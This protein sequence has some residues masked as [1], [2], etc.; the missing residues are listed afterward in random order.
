MTQVAALQM[1]VNSKVIGQSGVPKSDSDSDLGIFSE[2]SSESDEAVVLARSQTHIRVVNFNDEGFYDIRITA[3]RLGIIGAGAQKYH[4]IRNWAEEQ[5]KRGKNV[6]WGPFPRKR[7]FGSHSEKTM[8]ERQEQLHRWFGGLP[9]EMK[10]QYVQ[11]FSYVGINVEDMRNGETFQLHVSGD[12]PPRFIP[13]LIR[14]YLE[15][16]DDAIVNVTLG[17]QKLTGTLNEMDITDG[18]ILRAS[19][20]I[21]PVT[22][23][24]GDVYEGERN[25]ARG[26]HGLGICRYANGDVYQGEW[27]DNKENGHGT[28]TWARGTR[29]EGEW[30]NGQRH[31]EGIQTSHTGERYEGQWRDDWPDG[32]VK[33]T[34]P[35]G[36]IYEQQWKDGKKV[37]KS[38]LIA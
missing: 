13:Y 35:N 6:N 24:N 28:L 32:R 31:G 25:I 12:S 14:V 10:T 26:R 34:K 5:K 38:K 30:K 19:I 11:D 1:A 15:L 3:P 2:T 17:G 21:P 4:T 29:Y 33:F 7:L 20:T 23:R 22:F 18:S 27:R 16:P 37:S 36:Q 8:R 9:E